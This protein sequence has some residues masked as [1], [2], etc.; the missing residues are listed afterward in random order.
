MSTYVILSRLAPDTVKDPRELPRIAEDLSRAIKEHC[1][2]L[3]WVSSYGTVGHF[4]VVDIV[5]S[6][7]P[8]DVEKAASM[9]RDMGM[10]AETIA[11]TPWKEFVD[12]LMRQAGDATVDRE[13]P[14]GSSR[15]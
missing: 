8:L 13:T 15:W 9:L 14:G 10:G 4:D 2:T 6:D 3:T 12:N 5:E 7:N 11:L 1:P